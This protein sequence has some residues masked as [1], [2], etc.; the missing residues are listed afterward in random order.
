MVKYDYFKKCILFILYLT[1]DSLRKIKKS[2]NPKNRYFIF[3][4]ILDF[5]KKK[6]FRAHEINFFVE[7]RRKW[8]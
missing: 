6:F 7:K 8:C 3:C 5:S 4:K 2:W 1:F